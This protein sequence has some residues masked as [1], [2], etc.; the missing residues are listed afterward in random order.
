VLLG[1]LFLHIRITLPWLFTGFFM[2]YW[3]FL[4]MLIAFVGV[5]LSEIFHRQQRRILAEPLERT[6]AL[7]PVLPV[8]GFWM[9]PP[10]VDFSV[11]L[12]VVGSLYIALSLAR[13]SFR[14]GILA[15][16]AANGALWYFLSRQHGFA[17]YVHPQLWL[18]PPALCVLAAAYINR[19]QLSE[20]QMTGIRYLSSVTIYVS[21][22]AD[23]FT[24]GVAEAPWLPVVLGGL[25]ILGILLG[26]MLRVR[27]FLFLGTAFL[28]LALFTI[29]WHAAVDL[30]HTWLWWVT[31]IVA[32]V[33]MLLLF[34]LFEKRRQSVL[35]LM[36]KL[37]EWR[38]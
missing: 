29:I 21:S 3:P 5:G 25:S 4:V 33:L 27:A 13:Q 23:V 38:P 16:L 6:G 37:K 28:L 8:L 17:F 2:R 24:N 30:E 22:T 19:R 18:I 34:G 11:L 10:E 15:A 32:G 14:Y 36:E 7:L 1:L 35:E 20:S 31:G 9:L 26:I 12:L